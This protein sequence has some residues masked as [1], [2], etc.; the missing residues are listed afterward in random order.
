MIVEAI[1]EVLTFAG[2]FVAALGI[3][4]AMGVAAAREGMERRL[5]RN[6]KATEE[7]LRSDPE[8]ARAVFDRM[9]TKYLGDPN[10]RF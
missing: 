8:F 4:F 5:K 3:G 6:E 2:P 9:Y 10:R 1:Y 7:H